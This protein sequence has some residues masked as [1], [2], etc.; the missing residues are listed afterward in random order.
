MAN[1]DHPLFPGIKSMAG[2]AMG[3]DQI[4]ESIVYRLGTWIEL[5]YWMIM[6]KARIPVS[7]ISFLWAVLIP[8]I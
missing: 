6:L 1:A 3:F 4:V 8:I 7:S 2:K 5:I